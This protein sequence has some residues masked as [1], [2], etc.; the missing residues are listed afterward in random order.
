MRKD[1]DVPTWVNALFV[2][3]LLAIGALGALCGVRLLVHGIFTF[4]QSIL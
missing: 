2:L 3:V 1:C 4:V